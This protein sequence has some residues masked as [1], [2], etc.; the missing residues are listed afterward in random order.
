MS[1]PFTETGS[2]RNCVETRD[3]GFMLRVKLTSGEC[4]ARASRAYSEG[5]RVTVEGS[6]AQRRVREAGQT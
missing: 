1:N 6:G 2:V 5:A 4:G 3:G